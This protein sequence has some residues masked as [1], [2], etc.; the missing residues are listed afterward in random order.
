MAPQTQRALVQIEKGKT[1]KVV[2]D[3]PVPSLGPGDILVKVKAVTLNPT[4]WKHVDN[5]LEPGSSIGCDFAG[6][7]VEVGADAS[8]KG[9]KVGD[10]VAG[11]I[12]GG[13]V[14]KENGAFQEYVKVLPEGIWHKPASLS[15]EDASS[16]GGIALSTAVQALFYR[17]N[18]PKPWDPPSSTPPEPVLIWAGSTSVGL[19]GIALAKLSNPATPVVT[20]ASPH[21][22]G[23]LKKLGADAT[24]DYKDPE[25]GEKIRAWAK[26]K[27]Y[28]SG[29]QKALDSVSESGS[30]SL[31]AKSLGPKG[32][33]I[34]TLAPAK[35]AEGETWPEGVVADYILIYSVLKPKNA[36]D[37]ADIQEWYS[38][39][40]SLVIERGFGN[41][42][43]LEVSH[44]GLEGIHEGLDALRAKKV[45]AKKLAYIL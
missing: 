33:K 11:F 2:S 20:T 16:M 14:E 39:L 19:F 21:N 43:P 5:L 26:E 7:V 4:D 17:L 28:E 15:Y 38:H 34:V 37:F 41:A 3:H 24:F 35:P 13:F 18:L 40:P 9:F 12:R 44:A 8:S 22:H 31:I 10:P 30:T 45:S 32:G 25:V 42:I 6:D 27:G 1:P 36:Q 23:L 29:V